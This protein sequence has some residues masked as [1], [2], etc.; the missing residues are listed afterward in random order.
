MP[1]QIQAGEIIITLL[2]EDTDLLVVDKPAGLVVHPAYKHPDGTLFD[3]V[4]DYLYKRGEAR[5]CLLHRLDKDTSGA[6]ILTKT[7]QARQRLVRALEQRTLTK[8]YLGLVCGHPVPA[9][10]QIRARLRR[11]PA[12]RLRT[13]IHPLG[14]ESLTR[15]HT[16]RVFASGFSLLALQPITGR[17]HQLRIHLAALGTP[18]V[19]DHV[20]GEPTRWAPLHPSRHLLHAHLLAFQHPTTNERLTITAPLPADVEEALEACTALE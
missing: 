15:Y 9:V 11:D 3:A 12:D 10:G 2:Y 13:H 1:S 8:Q 16:L 17:T 19:G 18:L 5:P 20:Y 4:R 7:D 14:D 6:L